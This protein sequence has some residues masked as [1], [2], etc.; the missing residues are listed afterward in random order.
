MP[1]ALP[2]AEATPPPPA[3][4]L[5]H[6][7]AP[8]PASRPRRSRRL[9][10]SAGTA[11]SRSAISCASSSTASTSPGRRPRPSGSPSSSKTPST[12]QTSSCV[13]GLRRPRLGHLRLVAAGRTPQSGVPSSGRPS[14]PARMAS[15]I[16]SSSACL[17]TGSIDRDLRPGASRLSSSRRMSSLV[18]I[19]CLGSSLR[20]SPPRLGRVGRMDGGRCCSRALVFGPGAI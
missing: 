7:A 16:A 14:R 3:G 15:A 2:P 11:A 5:P 13:P 17:C 18:P 6:P 19:G 9:L 8:S 20:F 12:G 1:T 4:L 10:P